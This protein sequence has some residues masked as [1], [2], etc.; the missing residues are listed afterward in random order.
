MRRERFVDQRAEFQL[1][2]VALDAHRI[3]FRAAISRGAQRK[4]F[5]TD[6]QRTRRGGDAG[7]VPAGTF[8][9]GGDGEN[10]GFAADDPE[11]VRIARAGKDGAQRSL[12][13]GRQCGSEMGFRYC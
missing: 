12:R 3:L 7:D 6:R 13:G 4:L 11:V 1:V 5:E 8:A 9:C 10:A 2:R